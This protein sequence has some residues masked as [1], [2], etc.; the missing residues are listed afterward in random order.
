MKMN[1][2][3]AVQW[4]G[5]LADLKEQQYKSTLLICALAELLM[6][7]GILT[8][9]EIAQMASRLEDNDLAEG[10]GPG[11]GSDPLFNKR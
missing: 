5:Q 6:E 10:L 11:L 1:P 8:R 2:W 3:E 9:E 4:T 7:R